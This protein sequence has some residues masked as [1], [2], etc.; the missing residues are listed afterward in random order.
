MNF[1]TLVLAAGLLAGMLTAL[2]AQ[3][4]T[5]TAAVCSQTYTVQRGDTLFRIARRHNTTVANLQAINSIVNANRI[6]AGQR[7]CVAQTTS[8][9]YTVQRGDTLYSI[10]RYFGVDMNV[11]ARVNNITNPNRITVGQVLT[12]P[13]VT[14]QAEG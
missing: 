12:I 1:K 14:I 11:L 13:D 3:A 8:T 10:A 2:P 9:T 7:L 6:Y 5:G 4:Q